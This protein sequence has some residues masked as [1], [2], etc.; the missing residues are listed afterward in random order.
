MLMSDVAQTDE[1]TCT[2]CKC[3]VDLFVV[4]L[5]TTAVEF[6]AKC[7]TCGDK[8]AIVFDGF[9]PVKGKGSGKANEKK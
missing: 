4:I 3:T 8:M 9:R 7:P 2:K 6:R 1:F 5:D